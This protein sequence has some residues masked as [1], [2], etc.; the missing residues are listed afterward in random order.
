MMQRAM[1]KNR[2]PKLGRANTKEGAYPTI[3]KKD[4]M[5]LEDLVASTRRA[6]F[7]T[8]AVFPFDLFP[9]Q[10]SIEP[11]QVNFSKKSFFLTYHLQS[12]PIKNVADVFLQTSIFFA[13]L[14]VVD[15][16]YI[17]NS[18]EIDYLPKDHASKARRIIQGL[19][20]ATKNGVD[21]SKVKISELAQKA[22]KIG[23]AQSIDIAL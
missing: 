4:N 16:S 15:S 14:R 3:H 12:I 8:R 17:E 11:T 22:E 13:S 2:I 9:D 18:I 5:D 20:I 1:D 21:T 6:I 19:V 7:K 23:E 10:L